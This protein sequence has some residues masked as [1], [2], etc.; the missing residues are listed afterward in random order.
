MLLTVFQGSIGA[1]KEAPLLRIKTAGFNWCHGE[2]GRIEAGNVILD[3]VDVS[4]TE[5]DLMSTVKI[6]DAQGHR[7]IYHPWRIW[8]RVVMGINTEAVLGNFGSGRAALAKHVPERFGI[9][10]ILGNL[11]EKPIIATGSRI[12][13]SAMITAAPGVCLV[14]QRL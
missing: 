11:S 6:K 5:L 4:I 7:G 12:S 2:K 3:E 13:C 9:S 8:V 10:G 14:L 1:F